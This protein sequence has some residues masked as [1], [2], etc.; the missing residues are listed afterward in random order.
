[1]EIIE[2]GITGRLVPADDPERLAQ[3][4]NDLLDD[5]LERSRLG[6]NAQLAARER[7]SLTRMA[8]DTERIYREVLDLTN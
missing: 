6:H 7:F 2:D 3:V 5:P 8:R 4:I 1:L